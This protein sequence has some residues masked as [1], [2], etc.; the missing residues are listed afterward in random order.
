[1]NKP[2]TVSILG[3][4]GS[5]GVQTLEVIDHHPEQFEIRYLTTNKR[6]DILAAQIKRYN[7]YAVV[8]GD[9][10]AYKKFK[11]TVSF[12]GKILYGTEGL[13]EAASD[14]ANDLVISALVGFAGVVPTLSAIRNGIDVALANKET[15]VSAGAVIMNEAKE[16]N[17]KIR[18]IDSEHSAI[19]QCLVGESIDE[20]SKIIL[21]ASG[22]PFRS[23][24][25]SEFKNI[26]VEQALAHPNWSMGNKI[27]IDSA[28]MMNKGFE[29]IEAYWLFGLDF[30]QIEIVIHPQ[31][32]IHSLVEF[33]DGS[34]KAQLGMPDM[35]I[36]ISYAL[37]LPERKKYNFKRLDFKDVTTLTFEQP[38]FE[39]YP[40]LRL[41]Y[42][43]LEKFGTAPTILNAANEIAVN[44]FLDKKIKFNRIASVI[45]ETL[46]SSD[47]I[48]NPSIDEIIETDRETR[49][50]VK[51][52]IY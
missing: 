4:T 23:L 49:I 36:P 27:T 32:I 19:L 37:N 28:T 47:I 17:V 41:A 31:S 38:D 51:S 50:F 5:I 13:N 42:N 43:S 33:I 9:E 35:R 39:R 34:V 1:M 8:I 21:T 46:N 12:G 11:E 20:V 48:E 15:L 6:I 52:L 26:S 7:P 2:T 18:A 25:L 16:Y 29:L 10:K 3:S 22:G 45:E 40:C 30:E 14:T 24:P 44:A